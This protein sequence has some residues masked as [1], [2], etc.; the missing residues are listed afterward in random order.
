LRA[1]G[2]ER[3]GH[4]VRAIE[5]S[6]LMAYLVEHRIPLEVC[7]TSNVALGMYPSLAEHPLPS[8]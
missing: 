3:L 7:P 8:A 1:L 4:G 2:A 6:S 5:D